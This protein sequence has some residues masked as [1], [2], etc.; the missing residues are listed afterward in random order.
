MPDGK[1]TDDQQGPFV[2]DVGEHAADCLTVAARHARAL[3]LGHPSL[4]LF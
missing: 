4:T 1:C 2:A 3:I